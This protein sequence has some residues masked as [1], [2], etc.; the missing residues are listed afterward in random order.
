MDWLYLIVHVDLDRAFGKQAPFRL[1]DIGQNP[2]LMYETVPAAPQ[3]I[4]PRVRNALAVVGHDGTCPAGALA[5]F[6]DD[7]GPDVGEDS[8]VMIAGAH[9]DCAV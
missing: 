7:H 4:E 9:T 3:W 2:S 5:F 6:D 1:P 8:F